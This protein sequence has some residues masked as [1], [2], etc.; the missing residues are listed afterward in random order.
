LYENSLQATVAR[1]Y[2][3]YGPLCGLRREVYPRPVEMTLADTQANWV[4]S[5]LVSPY[6][7]KGS[8]M[9][10][11]CGTTLGVV[12]L[13]GDPR[14]SLLRKKKQTSQH[15]TT[16]SPKGGRQT[17]P[18]TWSS[19]P[20]CVPPR[21]HLVGVI[22]KSLKGGQQTFLQSTSLTGGPR[23]LLNSRRSSSGL[24]CARRQGLRRQYVPGTR[25]AASTLT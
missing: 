4:H 18:V 21:E 15:P 16:P 13:R 7:P 6:V 23:A 11:K 5:N 17:R 14:A 3:W 12:A 9:S 8:L 22:S 25:G 24:Y 1:T 10:A 19:P 20:S 2:P